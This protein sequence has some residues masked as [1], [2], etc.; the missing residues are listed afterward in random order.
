MRRER[1]DAASH[2]R[3]SEFGASSVG[4]T[5]HTKAFSVLGGVRIWASELEGHNM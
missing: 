4:H 3:A 1:G 2:F 5:G